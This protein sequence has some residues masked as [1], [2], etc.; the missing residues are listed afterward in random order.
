ME[1]GINQ[2]DIFWVKLDPVEGSEMAKTRPCIVISPNE[3]NNYLRTV[4]IVPWTTNLY[5][6]RWRVGV[7][8]DGQT[9]M[10]ALDHIRS[11]SKS[12]LVNRIGSLQISEIV[13]IKHVI[14]E[15]LVDT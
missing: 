12:R 2:Y 6:V 11:V 10:A 7:F 13:E 5:P 14:K 4:T 3:M 1:A 8:C 9:G 15:M